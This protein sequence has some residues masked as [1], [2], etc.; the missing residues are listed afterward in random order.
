MA[1]LRRVWGCC[2]QTLPRWEKAVL[3]PGNVITPVAP[4]ELLEFQHYHSK[5]AVFRN[6]HCNEW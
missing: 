1:F 5:M 2:G 4:A 6:Y 3:S